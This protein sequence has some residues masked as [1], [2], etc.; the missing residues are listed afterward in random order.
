MPYKKPLMAALSAAG[1][2]LVCSL[3]AL[4]LGLAAAYPRAAFADPTVKSGSVAVSAQLAHRLVPADGGK[5][6]LHIGL[7]ADRIEREDGR[8]PVNVALVVD[9]SGS[10]KGQRL[11]SAKRAAKE[12]LSR[13]SRADT[14]SLVAYNHQVDVLRHAGPVTDF[15]RLYSAVDRLSAHGRTALYA[16]VEEGA[17]QVQSYFRDRQV[18]RVILMSDGRANVGPSSPH[19]LSKLGQTLAQDGITVSTIGLGLNYNE[20]LMQQLALASDG[21]HAFAE[22]GDDLVRIF[23][24]EF[25]DTLGI[26][27]QDVE[28]LI[29]VRGGYSP[30][31]ILGRPGQIEG[32]RV[33]VKMA[34]L[35]GGFE[36]YV[37]V[38]LDA[39]A[40]AIGGEDAIAD[41]KVSYLDLASGQRGGDRLGIRARRSDDSKR[42]AESA[43]AGI[44]AKVAEQKVTLAEEEAVKLRDKGD[45]AGA[46][47]LLQGTL[48]TLGA[49]SAMP[50]LSEADR[51]RLTTK[52][53]TTKETAEALA[54]P[55][56]GKT[57]KKMRYEQLKSKRMQTY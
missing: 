15:S 55:E 22:T 1:L 13:L 46:R 19:E 11:S 33:K 42:I 23:N 4:I 9:Q 45:I 40:G 12:A 53:K 30:T 2:A 34:Q 51:K 24:S 41:V 25:G 28:I 50:A 7:I 47:Q 20:D 6:Y 52:Q 39:A 21:N 18:N 31:R 36:R 16:G 3:F 8:P 44:L 54:G 26:T 38:E 43:A 35:N 5:I 10:M 27:A 57:R 29:E 48:S 56:W 37:I 14:V 17:R 32:N 49:V